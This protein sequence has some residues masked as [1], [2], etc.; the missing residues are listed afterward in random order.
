MSPIRTVFVLRDPLASEYSHELGRLHLCHDLDHDRRQR[1]PLTGLSKWVESSS[2]VVCWAAK[3]V[4][5]I[6]LHHAVDGGTNCARLP[7]IASSMRS[8]G[9]RCR[10]SCVPAVRASCPPFSDCRSEAREDFDLLLGLEA[11]EK[12]V[13][14]V[15]NLAE[16]T[17]EPPPAA[18]SLGSGLDGNLAESW[19]VAAAASQC[20]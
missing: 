10:L 20:P 14:P 7:Y 3:F 11:Q 2:R 15:A 19:A 16:E 17:L 1:L 9:T 5:P 6:G 18:V 13:I 12:G 4:S 8:S